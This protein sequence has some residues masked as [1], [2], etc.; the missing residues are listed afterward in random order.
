[1]PLVLHRRPG[2]RLVVVGFGAFREAAEGLV[3]DLSRGDLGAVGELAARGRAAEGGPTGALRHLQG[4]LEGLG[5]DPG[6]RSS[7]LAAAQDLP[8]RVVFTGRLEHPELADLLPACDALVV[9]STFPEAFGMVA[10]EAA[11]CGALPIS[12]HHSGLAE[13][14]RTLAAAVPAG[15][16]PW[17]SFATGDVRG[18]ADRLVAWLQAPEPLREATREALVQVAR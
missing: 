15:A 14:T 17:L 4:F 3:A 2:A 12:A 8:E 7:Y 5:A 9:P 1:W 10:A 18:L 16:R 13:V 11:A 6:R